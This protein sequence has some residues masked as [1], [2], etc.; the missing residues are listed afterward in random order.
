MNGYARIKLL[1]DAIWVRFERVDKPN[2]SGEFDK[3]R[4]RFYQEI[5]EAKWNPE[6]RWMTLPVRKFERLMLFCRR[7]FGIRQVKLEK[8]RADQVYPN[9]CSFPF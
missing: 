5:P 2:R 1:P 7:E 9:Q 3:L 4:D 6:I 8:V